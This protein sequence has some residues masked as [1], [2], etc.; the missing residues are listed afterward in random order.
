M[1]A[2]EFFGLKE[3]CF[4][5]SPNPR[6]LHMT[7]QTKGCVFKAKYI[8]KQRHGLMAIIGKIGFGKTSVLRC[9]VNEFMDEPEFKMALLPNGT[10]STD[11]AFIKYISGQLGLPPRRSLLAQIQEMH[12][13]AQDVHEKGGNV[14]LFIDEAQGLKVTQLDMLREMLN[15]ETNEAKIIQIV[16][17]G[18][19][20]IEN[21]LRAKPELASRVMLAS[22]LD[23]F[24]FQDMESVLNH[25]IAVAGGRPDIITPEARHTLYI[26]SRGVPR[27]VVKIASAAMLIAA[28][29]EEPHI[30]PEFIE[31]AARNT[32]KIN[33]ESADEQQAPAIVH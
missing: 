3:N 29:A 17:A 25:R 16:L 1:E 31:E 4:A 22:Y 30:T 2:F 12:E 20:E 26:A 21:K 5:P 6:Y 9:L 13:F 18:Q 10:Y 24:T 33:T 7:D 11:M 27:E 28:L 15:Y 32:L 14:V 8:I 23:T 19:P